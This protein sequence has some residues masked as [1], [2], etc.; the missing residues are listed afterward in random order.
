[1]DMM[2]NR[3]EATQYRIGTRPSGELRIDD[4]DNLSERRKMSVMQPESAQQFPNTFDRVELWAVRRKEE[5]N[6]VGILGSPP[7]E[8][9]RG[10]V[11]LRVVDDDDNLATAPTSGVAKLAQE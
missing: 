9:E 11:I 1:L 3:T 5:Q 2:S 4:A 6:K 7:L 10:V 8:M